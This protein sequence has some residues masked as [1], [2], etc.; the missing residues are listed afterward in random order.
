VRAAATQATVLA[1]LLRLGHRRIDVEH[2]LLP[3]ELLHDGD[4]RLDFGLRVA[5]VVA[6]LRAVE[7]RRRDGKVAVVGIAVGDRLDV[8][9]DAE[10]LRNDDDGA[11]RLCL[12]CPTWLGTIGGEF[13]SVGC[14]ELDH[15]AHAVNLLL[16]RI[17][18]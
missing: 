1:R 4:P 15:L 12:I 14:G 7:H 16:D 9:V 5:G 10:D 13:V 6:A 2:R 8:G 11:A 17:P 18:L 3:V